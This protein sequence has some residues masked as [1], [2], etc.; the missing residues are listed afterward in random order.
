V[1]EIGF[2]YTGSSRR[3]VLK[4]LTFG[5]QEKWPR[6]LSP[7]ESFSAYCGLKEILGMQNVSKIQSVIVTTSC[8]ETVEGKSKALSLVI[9][10]ARELRNVEK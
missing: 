5:D 2:K 7:R 4:D 1:Y 3:A 8:N 9:S 6:K 10:Y